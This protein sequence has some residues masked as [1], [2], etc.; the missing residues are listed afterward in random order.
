MF[1]E[2]FAFRL[3]AIINFVGG[4]GK[5]ALILR[6][7]REY[8]ASLTVIYTTTVRIHPPHPSDG[9]AVVASD[10]TGLLRHFLENAAQ[11][12]LG[13][14]RT[15]VIT[16]ALMA[17]GLLRG[18]EPDF[19]RSIDQSSYPLILNEADGAR[20]MSLKM[21]RAG[22]PVLMEG[23]NCLV[24]VIGLDCINKPLGPETLFR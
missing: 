13:S 2:Q 20:S 23:A 11:T 14:V 5:T 18:V 16:R 1:S 6:L 15:L 4:G 10:D 19:A 24:P 9:L 7:A 3:P 17:P 12:C 21:P 22:E 8:S